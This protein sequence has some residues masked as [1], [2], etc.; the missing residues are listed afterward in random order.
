MDK[1]G[2]DYTAPILS[3]FYA[4]WTNVI[5]G[6]FW[7]ANACL[8]GLEIFPS[9]KISMLHNG[10][11]FQLMIIISWENIKNVNEEALA[12]AIRRP[13]AYHIYIVTYLWTVL[14]LKDGAGL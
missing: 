6:W 4:T 7:V 14:D 10:R 5:V 12:D 1:G 13:L 3:S 2:E 11:L 9:S 8:V